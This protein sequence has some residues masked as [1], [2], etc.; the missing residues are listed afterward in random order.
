MKKRILP[1]LLALCMV[2]SLLPVAFAEGTCSCT[3][4][5]SQQQDKPEGVTSTD[6]H[7]NGCQGTPVEGDENGLCAACGGKA[8]ET[9][10]PGPGGDPAPAE[11]CDATGCT[12]DKNHEGNHNNTVCNSTD[13]CGASSH[14]TG[15]DQKCACAVE[16]VHG[17]GA[18]CTNTKLADGTKC[19]TCT[20]NPG[21]DP[22]TFGDCS[23]PNGHEGA[24]ENTTCP[25]TDNSAGGA[26]AA[27]THTGSCAQKCDLATQGYNVDGTTSGEA[28]ATGCTLTKGHTGL[29]NNTV[30]IKTAQCGATGNHV[31]PVEA[32]EDDP[33]TE[34][35]DETVAAV[36]GC[37]NYVP[38]VCGKGGCTL[39]AKHP[40][41]H[42]NVKCLGYNDDGKCGVA[43]E[44]HIAGCSKYDCGCAHTHANFTT[45]LECT[46]K[47]GCPL[48]NA[49]NA[50]VTT[51]NAKVAAYAKYTEWQAK[52]DAYDDA[53]ADDPDQTEVADPGEWV[54][55]VPSD[56]GAAATA[57]ECADCKPNPAMGAVVDE[58][59]NVVTDPTDPAEPNIPSKAEE[60]TDME[61]WMA[62]DVQVAL[63]KGWLQGNGDGTFNGRGVTTGTTIAAVLARMDGETIT[64]ADW[65][66]DALAWAEDKDV[67]EGIELTGESMAR[68]DLVLV[69]WR[70]A[71]KPDS[72]HELDFTDVE[73]LEGDHLTAM[74]WAVENGIVK[75][76][77]DG[78]VTPDGSVNR[79]A[80]CAMLARY[81]A[82]EK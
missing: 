82:L 54:G 3:V 55:A 19:K 29:H 27:A 16:T 62:A 75:G 80:L 79:A 53:I 36:E 63:D 35:V 11:K 23:L 61:D 18:S 74:K 71:D 37:P 65:D 49:W 2:M 77:G 13:K 6:D 76:N 17:L 59:G 14:K 48:C 70:M 68:K 12:L 42:N 41:N 69:L 4:D 30:C 38:S 44:A 78:T 20:E 40:G 60:F 66:K 72:E 43:A 50:F 21:C 10:A 81:D 15:C 58:N 51:Q 39:Q 64:G 73:G 24:H 34:D 46:N 8:A 9:P 32:V 22:C 31:K 56:P 33:E 45:T 67:F 7:R 47:P 57:C 52:K 25:G 26:C 28:T 1:V 5:H